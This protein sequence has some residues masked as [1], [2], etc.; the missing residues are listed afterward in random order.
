[1]DEEWGFISK[2]G[3]FIVEPQYD[4]AYE[5]CEGLAPVKTG[6]KWGYID[7]EGKFIIEPQFDD[8]GGIL[9]KAW[10]GLKRMENL[11][12]STKKETL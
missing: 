1:V 12:I 8:A 9:V 4:E 11:V 6:D 7:K 2:E 10:Q 3:D 5:F